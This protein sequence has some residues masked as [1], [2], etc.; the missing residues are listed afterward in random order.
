MV[1][2]CFGHYTEMMLFGETFLD[3][4]LDDTD[5][6]IRY[7]LKGV[8]SGHSKSGHRETWTKKM[9]F[10]QDLLTK[11]EREMRPHEF[12]ST[13][14]GYSAKA[15]RWF[16]DK[17]KQR[18]IRPRETPMH[19]RNKVLLWLD[20][21]HNG[22]SGLQMRIK[23]KIGITTANNHI[24]D[25]L[26][27]ILKTFEQ[28]DVV[29]FPTISERQEMKSILEARGVPMP[30]AI[31]ALDGSHARCTG[32]NVRERLSFKYHFLP[33]FNVLFVTERAMK[34]ICAFSIDRKARKH[35]ITVLRESWFYPK[36]DEIM[37]GWIILAD[38]GYVGCSKEVSCIA[39]VLRDDM[40]DR[41]LFS[42]EYWRNM[43]VARGECERVFGDFFHNKFTQ[44]GKW[45]G[46]AKDTFTDFSMNVTCCIIL[47]NLIKVNQQKIDQMRHQSSL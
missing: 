4:I 7:K 45:P 25:V 26:M 11:Y 27:A 41:S 1:F 5:E 23:Y 24:K 17:I 43:N 20:K 10:E 13:F 29:R 18:L 9:F 35:D 30:H 22:L 31:F 33:C 14:A 44:L 36:L 32:R 47:Y 19:A 39:A 34:T 28:E 37:Q 42:N 8:G 40:D 38:K 21:L 46:K 15:L 12:K 6:L 16:F 2:V 3:F